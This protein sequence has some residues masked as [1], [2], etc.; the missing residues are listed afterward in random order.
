VIAPLDRL[1]PPGPAVRV[2][3]TLTAAEIGELRGS[4]FDACEAEFV[5]SSQ[6]AIAWFGRFLM[7]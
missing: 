3:A 7:S 2:A 5:A 1:T 4:H 6:A